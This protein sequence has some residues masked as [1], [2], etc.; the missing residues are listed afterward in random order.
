MVTKTTQTIDGKTFERLKNAP[1]LEGGIKER[2]QE[3]I[4]SKL[5]VF[6]DTQSFFSGDSEANQ[7]LKESLAEE[8]FIPKNEEQL[9]VLKIATEKVLYGDELSYIV[10]CP[11]IEEK[12]KNKDSTLNKV[13]SLVSI[14]KL[15]NE[16]H[17]KLIQDRTLKQNK[18]G[19]FL[20]KKKEILVDF[21]RTNQNQDGVEMDSEIEKMIK[22]LT[23]G[24][25]AAEDNYDKASFNLQSLLDNPKIERCAQIF[26]EVNGHIDAFFEGVK[27]KKIPLPKVTLKEAQAG[28]REY[29]DYTHVVEKM[30]EREVEDLLE[31]Q[32]VERN[33]SK[34]KI[35]TAV[36]CSIAIAVG[37]ITVWKMKSDTQKHVTAKEEEKIDSHS[38]YGISVSDFSFLPELELKNTIVTF[39]E[40]GINPQ[41]I[42]QYLE[43]LEYMNSLPFPS[44]DYSRTNEHI[45]GNNYM[46]H[47]KWPNSSISFPS[48][49]S[50]PKIS[51]YLGNAF[52][53]SATYGA[54]SF[55]TRFLEKNEL[56]KIN[57]AYQFYLGGGDAIRIILNRNGMRISIK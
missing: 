12:L 10:E 35:A 46:Q 56:S 21:K 19:V 29:L 52:L 14:L 2:L 43:A 31:E 15:I 13:L 34:T 5:L 33:I 9:S 22:K 41:K 6:L 39:I 7:F 17:N 38:I 26:K 45:G 50:N 4:K 53:V 27:E 32:G 49:I 28:L 24:V 18:M 20:Q 54:D 16:E 37:A 48:V 30:Q 11:E 23:D 25:V 40:E 1:E 42:R 55:P 36:L 57:Y 3:E 44:V 51:F 47:L 8:L